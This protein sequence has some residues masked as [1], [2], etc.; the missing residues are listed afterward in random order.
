MRYF[1]GMELS[2]TAFE[3]GHAPTVLGWVQTPAEAAAWAGLEGV[4]ADGG[5]FRAWHAEPWSH[6]YVALLGGTPVAYGEVWDDDGE[7]E[8]ARLIVDPAA[9]GRGVG[10]RLA[11]LLAGEA[12]AMGYS[13]VW[14]RVLP[15]NA[16][17]LAAYRAVGFLPASPAQERE[18]N[19]GQPRPY[20]WLLGPAEGEP[21]TGPGS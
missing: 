4:P 11:A 10:R 9:R 5:V 3:L 19:A 16:A 1:F 14:L 6:P 20:R 13:A 21:G 18:F 2:L 15:D 17:A 8:L 12:R 7:A